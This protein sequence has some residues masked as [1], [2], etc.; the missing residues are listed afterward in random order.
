MSRSKKHECPNR[1]ANVTHSAWSFLSVSMTVSDFNASG[2]A[3]E[4]DC[5]KTFAIGQ[6]LEL[7]YVTKRSEDATTSRDA[8]DCLTGGPATDLTCSS[9][10]GIDPKALWNV[11]AGA[12]DGF[13]SCSCTELG[14]SDVSTTVAEESLI[15]GEPERGLATSTGRAASASSRAP[16]MSSSE[17][18]V[19]DSVKES[20]ATSSARA[21]A[22]AES[23]ESPEETLPA[24][25]PSRPTSAATESSNTQ[26]FRSNP[27]ESSAKPFAESDRADST[28]ASRRLFDRL[29]SARRSARR[30]LSRE[31]T[32]GLPTSSENSL[33]LPTRAVAAAAP[34]Q[35]T[36]KSESSKPSS[37]APSY[38]SDS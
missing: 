12:F 3:R 20:E 16:R 4:S 35:A 18:F 26:P 24:P 37:Y 36:W 27:R 32:F 8:L 11:T 7:A 6:Y 2:A 5:R 34:D 1:C 31:T 9:K 23:A 38:G 14:A 21:N 22:A 10:P 30:A 29:C 33:A 25:S 15:E 19:V 13:V 28:S 17:R